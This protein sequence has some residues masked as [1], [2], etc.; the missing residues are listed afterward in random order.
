MKKVVG[1]DL[2]LEHTGAVVLRGAAEYSAFTFEGRGRLQG[3]ER[4][5]F[6]RDKVLNLCAGAEKV[7]IEGYAFNRG[8]RAHQVGELGG[9]VRTALYEAGIEY[10]EVSPAALKRFATGRGNADKIGVATAV[11]KRWGVMLRT[12]H[13]YDAFVLA[14][15]GQ[16]LTGVWIGPPLTSFQQEVVD[17]IAVAKAK[18]CG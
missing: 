4:L 13:E 15:I 6:I 10:L 9:V 16:A 8:N 7:L 14:K 2:S 1:L 18:K 3:P 12:E 17:R 5:V 11:T